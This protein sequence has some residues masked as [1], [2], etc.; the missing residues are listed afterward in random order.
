MCL[1]CGAFANLRNCWLDGILKV[2]KVSQSPGINGD[3]ED[4][5][6][7]ANCPEWYEYSLLPN[8]GHW[9]GGHDVVFFRWSCWKEDV[10]E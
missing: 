4:H 10:C 5:N 1:I 8:D 3:D 9:H 6:T 2:V 7:Y